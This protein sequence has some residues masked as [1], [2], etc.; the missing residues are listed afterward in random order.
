[1]STPDP[2]PPPTPEPAWPPP[3]ARSVAFFF[4]LGLMGFEAVVRKSADLF[5]YG[6][7]FA[8]TGLPLVKGLEA[9]FEKVGALMGKGKP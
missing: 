4:G 3:W 1:M 7:A 9:L 2:A 6:P 5:L 8:L